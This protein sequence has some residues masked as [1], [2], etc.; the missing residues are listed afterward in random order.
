[1]NSPV[2]R[3]AVPVPL[4]RLFDYLPPAALGNEQAQM[5]QPGLRLEVPF[6]RRRLVGILVEVAQRSAVPQKQLRHA[7]SVL[8]AQPLTPPDLVE[9]CTW[10]AAYYQHGPG[11]T[12]ATALPVR[13]RRPPKP[14]RPVFV[15]RLTAAGA[16]AEPALLQTRAPRQAALLGLLQ[17]RKALSV[18][19]LTAAGFTGALRKGLTDKGL[20]EIVPQPRP[21]E[22]L[23]GAPFAGNVR[24]FAQEAMKGADTENRAVTL[25]PEQ[26]AAVSAI[27]AALGRFQ[28]FLLDGVT[29]SG[30]TEVY[31]ELI[32]QVLAQGRQALVLVPEIGLTPQTAARFAQRFDVPIALLHSGIE[33]KE[34]LAAWL[35]AGRGEARIVIG[36]RSA[37]FTPLAAPGLLVVDEEHDTSYKQQDGLRYSARD[38]AVVRARRHRVPVVLGSATPSLESLHNAE[39]GRYQVLRLHQRSGSSAPPT[40]HLLDLRG[41]E[42]RG[43]IS[44]IL[45]DA[46][47]AELTAGSQVLLF[48]N[49]RGYAPAL[50]C[51]DCGWTADCSDCDARMVFHS[52]PSR[53]C[54]H[55]CD[56]SQPPPAACPRCRSAYLDPTGYGT[57]RAEQVLRGQFPAVPVHRIDRDAVSRGGSLPKI[58]E[59][60]Q[61]G[62]PCI[63]VGTQMLAKGHHFPEVTL[64]AVLDGDSGL[65]SPDFRAPER[66]AQLLVQVAGRAGRWRKP[67]AIW[68]QTRSPEHPFFRRLFEQGYAAFAQEL[69]AERRQRSLPPLCRMAL[70]RAEAQRLETAEHWLVSVRSWLEKTAATG[71]Q[72][73]GPVAAP[74]P[75]RAGRCRALLALYSSRLG[76]LRDLLHNFC[77]KTEGQALPRGLRWSVDMDPQ[78]IL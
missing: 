71:V 55:H 18:A 14:A 8:D 56:A 6:G 64:S 7:L 67:S 31:L 75:R 63:L 50:I 22:Q 33:E 43:G 54:C 37:V 76:P 28:P 38:L 70:L 41:A 30:K 27:A 77:L 61:R 46:I 2:L 20:A 39:R 57:Q 48:L 45:L 12:L 17:T 51:R 24:A 60:I 23:T 73:M 16:Q 29:S 36:T 19:E 49:R 59:E 35:A 26:Q 69:L 5:L 52:R 58:L 72:L 13:L 53:L 21:S 44:E 32:A 34:R 4:R 15:C 10:A 65:F 74:L 42:L 3:I 1:M 47:G 11:E 78:E 9:L 62:R 25:R 68:V 40:H 66:L